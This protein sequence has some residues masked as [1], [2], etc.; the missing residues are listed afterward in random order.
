MSET[1]DRMLAEG[2]ARARKPRPE[3]YERITESD[4]PKLHEEALDAAFPGAK[5]LTR[6]KLL[7][8]M[9]R[10][11]TWH[12]YVRPHQRHKAD[13]LLGMVRNLRDTLGEAK[14]RYAEEEADRVVAAFEGSPGV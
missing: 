12:D 1:I 4:L 8:L 2:R 14:R 13:P 7:G 3:W 5:P 6:S 11:F 10:V 9:K